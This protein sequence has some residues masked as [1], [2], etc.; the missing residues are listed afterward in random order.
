V[1]DKAEAVRYYKLAVDQNDTDAQYDYAVCLDDGRD[2]VKDEVEAAKY[3]KFAADQNHTTTQF[4]DALCFEDGRDVVK[5][6]A[7][8]EAAGYFNLTAD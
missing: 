3:F 5:D 8:A 2:V 7:E 4:H 6:E 1:T